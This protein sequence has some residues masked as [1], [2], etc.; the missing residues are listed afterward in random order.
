MQDVVDQ[1]YD[2]HVKYVYFD[3]LKTFK[4]YFKLLSSDKAFNV[5]GIVFHRRGPLCKKIP[6][7]IKY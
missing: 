4:I 3:S 1:Q 6:F 2:S 7:T 5:L